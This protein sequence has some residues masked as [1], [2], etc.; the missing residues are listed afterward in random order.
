MSEVGA[1]VAAGKETAEQS[2]NGWV[3]CAA[4]LDLLYGTV[5]EGS[6]AGRPPPL[7]STW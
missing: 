7:S 5:R 3:T 4:R 6:G 2:G 1:Q